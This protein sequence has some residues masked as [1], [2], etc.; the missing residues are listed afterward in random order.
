[1]V[2]DSMRRSAVVEA[3]TRRELG[4]M[5]LT[6]GLGEGAAG[7]NR[8]LERITLVDPPAFERLWGDICAAP[9]RRPCLPEFLTS[10]TLQPACAA[11]R[12][13]LA[14]GVRFAARRQTNP[15]SRREINDLAVRECLH[16]P[17]TTPP[18]SL[19]DC[20]YT[21]NPLPR[22]APSCPP[23]G[24]FGPSAP[25][26]CPPAGLSRGTDSHGRMDQPRHWLTANGQRLVDGTRAAAW[27]RRS[28]SWAGRRTACGLAHARTRRT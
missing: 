5:S 6:D 18:T 4:Q 12:G 11:S 28:R 20:P 21:P 17:K 26:P 8:R 25:P 3:W 1:M 22:L 2:C 15:S 10:G 13:R 27:S 14:D 16:L 23:A 19:Q 7:R 9:A 24:P